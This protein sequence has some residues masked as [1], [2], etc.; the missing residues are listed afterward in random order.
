M[1]NKE[2]I[3]EWEERF[4]ETFFLARGAEP[5]EIS[6]FKKRMKDFIQTELRTAKQQEHQAIDKGLKHIVA[7]I[8]KWQDTHNTHHHAFYV[9]MIKADLKS[10]IEK[11]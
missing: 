11:L 6:S 4:D 2:E 7:G 10:Y 9:S 8:E 5:Y 3:K 1:M